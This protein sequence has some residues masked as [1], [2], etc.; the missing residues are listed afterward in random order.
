M[1]GN[2]AAY[3]SSGCGAVAACRIQW[4]RGGPSLPPTVDVTYQHD[5]GGAHSNASAKSVGTPS[6]SRVS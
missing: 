3:M 5:F 2:M 1:A 6:A 4:L